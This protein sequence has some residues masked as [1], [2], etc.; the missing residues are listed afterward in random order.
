VALSTPIDEDAAEKPPKQRQGLSSAVM[1]PAEQ[2]QAS[3]AT[4]QTPFVSAASLCLSLLPNEIKGPPSCIFL[5]F[6]NTLN[7][8]VLKEFLYT[9]S[10]WTQ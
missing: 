10:S 2:G 5:P 9:L 7:K 1:L 3:I 4:R 8:L 6:P